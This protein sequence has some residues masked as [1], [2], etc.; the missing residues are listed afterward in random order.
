M[1]VFTSLQNNYF[2]RKVEESPLM[3]ANPS[4][5][6]PYV[7]SILNVIAPFLY[8][9]IENVYFFKTNHFLLHPKIL[10]WRR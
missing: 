6:S 9:F 7:Y 8:V 10:Y 2:G 3:I 5:F 1:V 4:K